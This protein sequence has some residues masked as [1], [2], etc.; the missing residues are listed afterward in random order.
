MRKDKIQVKVS[1]DW[2]D[3]CFQLRVIPSNKI[4]CYNNGD[5]G[6]YTTLQLEKHMSSA[7]RDFD[8]DSRDLVNYE[9]PQNTYFRF[10]I[11]KRL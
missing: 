10:L 6:L 3:V 9:I 8:E 7:L 2:H 11:D 5:C 1:H 4:L